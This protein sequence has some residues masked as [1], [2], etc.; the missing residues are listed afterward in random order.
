MC[1]T[2]STMIENATNQAISSSLTC[3]GLVQQHHCDG[4]GRMLTA[5][6]QKPQEITGDLWSCYECR[7][8]GATCAVP[9]DAGTGV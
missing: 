9:H 2:R 4:C 1:Y 7:V 8:T 5:F 3:A 6:G